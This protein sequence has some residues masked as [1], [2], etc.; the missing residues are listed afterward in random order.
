MR[1]SALTEWQFQL[2]DFVTTFSYIAIRCILI[3]S[4][5]RYCDPS[6]LLVAFVCSFLRKHFSG[7]ISRKRSVGDRC[8]VHIDYEQEIA[9]SESS[10]HIIDG[11]R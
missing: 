3:T 6:C 2:N 1:I 5:R 8:S 7:R 10:S 11:V 9:C 4:A